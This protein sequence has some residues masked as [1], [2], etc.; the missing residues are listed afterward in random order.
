MGEE[1]I[2]YQQTAEVVD[3]LVKRRVAKKAI[4]DIHQQVEEIDKQIHAE[5]RSARYLLPLI[6]IMSILGIYF[7]VKL[8]YFSR[9]MSSLFN[10]G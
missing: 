6:L 7:L 9:I 3:E 8:P 1:K 4:R 10:A 5:K 2:Q